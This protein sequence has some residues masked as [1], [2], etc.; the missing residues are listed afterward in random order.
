MT[1]FHVQMLVAFEW[2]LSG[3]VFRNMS[4]GHWVDWT[5]QPENLE[6]RFAVRLLSWVMFAYGFMG[7]AGLT[8]SPLWGMCLMLGI[9]SFWLVYDRRL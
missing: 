6:L 5:E 8:I 2:F 3:V 4:D 9:V 7:V 1:D